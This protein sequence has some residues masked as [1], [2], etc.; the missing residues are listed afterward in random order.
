MSSFKPK[1]EL[2][3]MQLGLMYIGCKILHIAISIHLEFYQN[4]YG[5]KSSNEFTCFVY[6]KILKA[7]QATEKEK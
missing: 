4:Y 6:N 1:S 7:S 2:D 3:R 5:Y